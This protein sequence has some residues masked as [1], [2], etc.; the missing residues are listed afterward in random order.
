MLAGKLGNQK[1]KGF[2]ENL[3][4]VILEFDPLGY[5]GYN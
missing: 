4:K 5:S 3:E 1:L 2:G